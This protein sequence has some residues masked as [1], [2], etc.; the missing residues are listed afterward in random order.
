MGD[1]WRINSGASVRATE[2]AVNLK[3]GAWVDG[4]LQRLGF[5]LLPSR[6]LLCGGAG[7]VARDLCAACRADLA[8]NEPACACCGQPLALAAAACGR[9]LR[10]KPAFQATWAPL[11]YAPP[12]AGLMTRFKFGG[13]L[14]AGRVLAEIALEH[15]HRLPPARPD[16]L[17]PVPLH[18]DRLRERGYNQALELARPIA[19]ATGI[20]LLPDV[21]QRGRAT[22]AQ[23]GLSALARR[24][25]LRGA[26][27]VRAGAALPAHVAVVDD[28]MTT[29]ATA[30]ECALALRRAGVVRV[31]V[32]A[33]ARA[34]R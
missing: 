27:A 18:P 29:G 9:C 15:W 7:A 26:F 11:R 5:A 22:P 1:R 31:D 28:V 32:W 19:R 20:P 34:P 12:L 4:W 17:L 3:A 33:V 13:D 16:T 10:R 30:Q 14:A 25:N 2:E 8:P 21:L 24:R 6:C 23:S